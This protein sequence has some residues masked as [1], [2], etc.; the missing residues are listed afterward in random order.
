M[1]FE[2]ASTPET[3]FERHNIC[4]LEI[5]GR[6]MGIREFNLYHGDFLIPG[7]ASVS[8]RLEELKK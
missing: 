2:T 3:R 1:G 7:K 4:V 8:L 6:T 5:S